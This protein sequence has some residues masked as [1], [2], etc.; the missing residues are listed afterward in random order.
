MRQREPGGSHPLGLQCGLELL[1]GLVQLEPVEQFVQ[2]E[3]F[4]EQ[5]GPLE[6]LQQFLVELVERLRRPRVRAMESR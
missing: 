6:Q 5:L 1:A 4:V 3:Q 2:L